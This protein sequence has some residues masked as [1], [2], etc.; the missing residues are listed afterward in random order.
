MTARYPIRKACPVCG[1]P[2]QVVPEDQMGRERYVCTRCE[3]DPMH[4]SGTADM[5]HVPFL[6]TSSQG[7]GCRFR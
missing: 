2:M 5:G 6:F 1:K 7:P 4:A 3:H